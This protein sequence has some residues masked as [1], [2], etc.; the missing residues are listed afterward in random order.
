MQLL[1]SSP[2]L[3]RASCLS[4]CEGATPSMCGTTMYVSIHQMVWCLP[5]GSG[6]FFLPKGGFDSSSCFLTRSKCQVSD[7][8][9]FGESKVISEMTCSWALK[10]VVLLS[11]RVRYPKAVLEKIRNSFAS[12]VHTLTLTHTHIPQNSNISFQLLSLWRKKKLQQY[13]MTL[14]HLQYYSYLS[15]FSS[16]QRA[17]HASS[18]C[19]PYNNPV[20]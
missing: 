11:Q 17:P 13:F 1:A 7:K 18:W 20:S 10:C 15:A 19:G 5:I 8:Q 16:A 9:F 14:L 12:K 4:A 3:Q 6:S 2:A